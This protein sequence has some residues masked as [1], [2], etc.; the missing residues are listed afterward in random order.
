[1]TD[2]RVILKEGWIMRYTEELAL[3][4]IEEINLHQGIVGRLLG[5][6]GVTIQ[7]TGAGVIRTPNM[8]ANPVGFRKAIADARG[9]PNRAAARP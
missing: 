1:V 7:G 6:G 2:R 9:S 8:M 3:T 4:S 5:Y